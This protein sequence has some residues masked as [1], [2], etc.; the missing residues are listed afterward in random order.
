MREEGLCA[1]AVD[2]EATDG[3]GAAHH[4]QLLVAPEQAQV[5]HEPVAKGLPLPRGQLEG[6]R[7]LVR[8]V[9]EE[10]GQLGQHAQVVLIK[11]PDQ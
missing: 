2:T 1:G 3:G 8:L 5:G 6:R 4:P 9:A 7:A 11:W 10:A